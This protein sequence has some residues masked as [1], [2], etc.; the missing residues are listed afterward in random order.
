MAMA[1]IALV[2]GGVLLLAD[3]NKGR[4]IANSIGKAVG[5]C[6]LKHVY[7]YVYINVHELANLDS[8][9]LLGTGS[10]TIVTHRAQWPLTRYR[11]MV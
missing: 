5:M 11:P 1:L 8:V 10:E 6:I 9:R 7:T 4:P 2:F 3:N